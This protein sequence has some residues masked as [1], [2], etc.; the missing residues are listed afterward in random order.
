MEKSNFDTI[1][2]VLSL[3]TVYRVINCASTLK[4]QTITD[5]FKGTVDRFTS[6]ELEKGFKMLRLKGSMVLEE[7][8]FLIPSVKSGPN[9][10]IA[11]LGATLDAKAF[12][13]DSRLL[14]YAET[15]SAVTAPSLFSLLKEEINNLGS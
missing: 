3:L 4:L 8:K 6:L 9:Y 12:S 1:R 5:P 7:N 13:E 14:S 15:V 10:K 11:A 2:A